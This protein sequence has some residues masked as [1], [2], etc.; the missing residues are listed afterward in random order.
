MM[1]AYPETAKRLRAVVFP[2]DLPVIG[3]VAGHSWSNTS[4]E[5]A[6]MRR[7]HAAFVAASP[8]REAVLASD[9]SH[10]VMRDRPELVIDAIKRMIERARSVVRQ[11]TPTRQ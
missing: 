10:Y 1:Q 3:I 6:A 2:P 8:A 9:S 11:F 7:V 4:E 5:A